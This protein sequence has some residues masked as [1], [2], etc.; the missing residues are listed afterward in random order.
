MALIKCPECGREIS[1]MAESCPHCGYPIHKSQSSENSSVAN[2]FSNNKSYQDNPFDK[3]KQTQRRIGGTCSIPSNSL[4]EWAKKWTGRRNRIRVIWFLVD[5]M[6][7][8][9]F[10]VAYLSTHIFALFI[11]TI[12]FAILFAIPAGLARSIRTEVQKCD[13]HVIVVH[14]SFY[15]YLLVDGEILSKVTSKTLEG[16]LPDG[17]KVIAVIPSSRKKPI[18]IEVKNTEDEI[19][20]FE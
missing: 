1:S 13:D 2:P 4:P 12:V 7:V 11:I 16:Y 19:D 9:S 10:F 5:V 17:R 6:T 14:S 3:P 18:K 20:D 8:F 15:K